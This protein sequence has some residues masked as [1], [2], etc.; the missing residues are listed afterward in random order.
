MSRRTTHVGP[1]TRIE[2]LE[3]R[4]LLA[5]GGT[6]DPSFSGDGITNFP[7]GAGIF[8]TDV[9]LQSDGKAVVVGTHTNASNGDTQFAVVRYNIDGSPDLTFGIDG[10]V[11]TQLSN[12]GKSNANAVAIAPDGKIVVVG[13]A[14]VAD[15]GFDEEELAVARYLPT[16]A[17][18]NTFDDN[19]VLSKDLAT[20]SSSW[21][22]ARDVA[23]QPGFTSTARTTSR[24]TRMAANSS[25]S[26]TK[27][28]PSP[29]SSTTPARSSSP[30]SLTR[31]PSAAWP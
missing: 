26:P 29:S 16:G 10:I 28:P 11:V 25:T 6:L 22:R 18:D 5:V 1:Y 4:Q 23:V 15:A 30:A 19:G 13:T 17:L 9:A 3:R 27:T 24:L 21:T 20:I 2:S 31:V 14:F 7:G 8:A 12:R